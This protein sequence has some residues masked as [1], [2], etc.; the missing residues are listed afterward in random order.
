MSALKSHH[1]WNSQNL[2]KHQAMDFETSGFFPLTTATLES[3][4]HARENTNVSGKISGSSV[5]FSFPSEHA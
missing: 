1:E 5:L 4:L 3:A 2:Q